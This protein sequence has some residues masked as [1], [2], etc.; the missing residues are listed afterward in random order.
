MTLPLRRRLVRI[1]LGCCASVAL[2]LAL[3]EAALR[4]LPQPVPQL[5]QIESLRGFYQLDG[6]GR[7]QVAP[8]WSGELQV[9]GR[10]TALRTN[11]L[12]L[13]GP[14]PG[15]GRPRVLVL[16]DSFAMGMGVEER[17]AI[18]ARLADHLREEGV[19]AVVGNAGMWGTSPREWPHTLAR[20]RPG[21]RPDAVVA[22]CYAGNDPADL[23]AGPLTV[24][25][26]YP[27][28]GA[29]AHVVAQSWRWRLGLRSRTW[30]YFEMLFLVRR[31]PIQVAPRASILPAGVSPFEGYFLDVAPSAES[32]A[33]WL[34]PFDALFTASMRSFG[35][36]TGSMPSLVVVLPGR[37]ASSPAMHGA[38]LQRFL[39]GSGIGDGH[40]HEFA[41]GNGSRRLARLA[42]AAGLRTLDLTDPVL[43]APDVDAL[44]L[45]DYHY[46]PLGCERVA[47]WIASA[48]APLLPR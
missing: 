32:I 21:F 28:D 42:T 11:S 39:A 29:T 17:E 46:T 7:L 34:A 5:R 4:L 48:L 19:D 6:E 47:G 41:A 10:I 15:P 18:P 1:L 22:L 38:G 37:E 36:A 2:G 40:A 8:N 14:E 35:A 27:L 13:R 31:A 44:Y 43:S 16:G 25:D 26:G 3:L 20:F 23:V 33:P 9:D 45:S 24:V 12:G 30:W